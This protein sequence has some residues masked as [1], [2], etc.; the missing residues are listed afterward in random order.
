MYVV[1]VV[2]L[3]PIPKGAAEMAG[4]V[5][6]AVAATPDVRVQVMPSSV[7]LF[8]PAASEAKYWGS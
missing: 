5:P 6:F 2:V 4:V 7:K 3:V 8:S 1:P